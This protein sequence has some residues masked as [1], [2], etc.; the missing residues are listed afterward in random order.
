MPNINDSIID[1]NDFNAEPQ[2]LRDIQDGK[3]I[4]FYS[5]AHLLLDTSGKPY[6]LPTGL[7]I[8]GA[9]DTL[10]Q[11][12]SAFPTG[13]TNLYIVNADKFIY[14]WNGSTWTKGGT[15]DATYAFG[16]ELQVPNTATNGTLTQE[17]FNQLS[18]NENAYILFNNERY[19]LMDKGHE[20]D[21]WGY[22]H[23]GADITG[24]KI[25]VITINTSN[26]SWVLTDEEFVKDGTI[27]TQKIQDGAVMPSKMSLHTN[28]MYGSS[29][30]YFDANSLIA[31]WYDTEVGG[32]SSGWKHTQ[33]IPV[34]KGTRVKYAL[35]MHKE[36]YAIVLLDNDQTTFIQGWYNKAYTVDFNEIVIPRDGYII[37]NVVPISN[38][39]YDDQFLFVIEPRHQN[40]SERIYRDVF[41]FALL[42]DGII[43]AETG[44]VVITQFTGGY[45][46]TDF[47]PIEDNDEIR[48]A[49][50]RGS[51]I[52]GGCL[53]DENKNRIATIWGTDNFEAPTTYLDGVR[54]F[55][56]INTFGAKYI[57]YTVVL[58]DLF[59][60]SSQ[61]II[62]GKNAIT[63]IKQYELQTPTI[64]SVN[65]TGK[66]RTIKSICEYI[67]KNNI[68]N[69]TV[70]VSAQTYDLVQEFGEET[71][72]NAQ[73]DEIQ[74]L[75]CSNN[76]HFKFMQGAKVLFN[77][78]GSNNNILSYFSPFNVA[79][80]C[81]FENLDIEVTNCRYCVHDD[82]P[83]AKDRVLPYNSNVKYINCKMIHNGYT[84][85]SSYVAP[86]CIGGGTYKNSSY[87]IIG[88]YYENKNQTLNTPISYH[89]HADGAFD[90]KIVLKDV[91]FA[92]GTFRLFDFQWSK[93][94]VYVSGCSFKAPPYIDDSEGKGNCKL[95]A[96]NNEIRQG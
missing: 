13:N 85:T 51:N 12:Q 91:Y 25:K 40:A 30:N 70:V 59:P 69:A 8:R 1:F 50:I 15:I 72:N 78:G 24:A 43:D 77:Y 11:L 27:S 56:F 45:T 57:R 2:L 14:Y 5:F 31:G 92:N 48:L 67:Q 64:Y 32:E 42:E 29:R 96:W 46:C 73:P 17:Q 80:S 65:N 33:P 38:F 35:N 55:S 89:N 44:N 10:Q 88:G 54:D 71:L 47:I 19:L 36:H 53:Y 95:Y 82:M 41:D 18:S 20:A 74:G 28:N 49:F 62:I 52:C 66:F 75:Y 21:T 3:A 6:T 86:I 68:W 37:Y 93:L 4:A 83:A 7:Y 76:T 16:V 39:S 61:Y 87:E 26:R 23:L 63:P 90:E 34:A 9:Y 79:G 22:S 84:Q 58:N 94:N 81:T 60:H